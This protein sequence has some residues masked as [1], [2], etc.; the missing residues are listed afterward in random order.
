MHIFLRLHLAGVL[1]RNTALWKK[2]LKDCMHMQTDRLL[3]IEADKI[4]SC[5]INLLLTE[6]NHAIINRQLHYVPNW[7]PITTS[8][9]VK[10]SIDN[11]QVLNI[12]K[13]LNHV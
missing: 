13:E 8:P 11:N 4:G 10:T 9:D 6:R 2:K 1:E 3:T 12:T 7:L 5:V